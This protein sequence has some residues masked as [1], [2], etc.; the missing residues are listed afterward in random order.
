MIMRQLLMLT[1]LVFFITTFSF[2]QSPDAKKAM[3][4]ANRDLASFSVSE[5]EEKLKSAMTSIEEALTDPTMAKSA[6][7]WD[8]KGGIYNKVVSHHN[9]LRFL[10][11]S[12]DHK[13]LD[14]KAAMKAY[15]AYNKAL[16]LAEKKPEI[17]SALKGMTATLDNLDNA[18]RE[19]FEA[20]DYEASFNNFDAA[21]TINDILKENG[22]ATKLDDPAIKNDLM[23]YTGLAALSYENMEGAK[24]YFEQLV[25]AKYDEPYVYDSMYR[26]YKDENM[27]KALEFLNA[28]REAYPEDL[29]LL[30]T[31]IN[32][33]L[34]AGQM[35]EL[36]KRLIEAIDKEPTNPSLHYTLG[37]VYADLSAKKKEEGDAA[38]EEEFMQKALK[39][40]N[41]ALSAKSDYYEGMYGIG[42]LYYNKAAA[43]SQELEALP[44]TAPADEYKALK[45]SM[46]KEFENALPYFKKAEAM[47]PNDPNTLIALSE[48]FARQDE[49]DLVKVFKDRL[50]IVRDGGTN[51]ASYFSLD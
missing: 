44:A 30:F 20:K 19:S 47:N 50:Q 34:Q 5:D 15:E 6:K 21:F 42:E 38:G 27:D 37:R 43:I 12:E 17:R 31:E 9:K 22:E 10:P 36:E 35:A 33:Y 8:I 40:Y 32:H 14:P 45:S 51:E 11:G 49:F 16:D 46:D 23:Y 18:G 26:I 1:G 39:K 13:I 28:G 2:A 25:E 4:K 3:K 41:D 48:I 29:N 24:K 7:A